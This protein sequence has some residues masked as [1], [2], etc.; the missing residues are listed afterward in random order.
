VVDHRRDLRRAVDAAWR[1]EA[2]PPRVEGGELV[3]AVDDHGHAELL[4]SFE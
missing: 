3:A 1:R 4:E 2:A